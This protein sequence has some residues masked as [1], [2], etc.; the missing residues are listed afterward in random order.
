M[1]FYLILFRPHLQ[2]IRTGLSTKPEKIQFS[3]QYAVISNR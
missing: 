1:V 2:K 3:K